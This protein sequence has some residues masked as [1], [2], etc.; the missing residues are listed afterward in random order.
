MTEG[1]PIGDSRSV[2]PPRKEG[3][4]A[5]PEKERVGELVTMYLR[6]QTWWASYQLDRRQQRESLKTSNR[7]E[8]RRKAPII[9]VELQR[10]RRAAP[11]PQVAIA[12]ATA[13]YLAHLKVEGLAPKTLVK[14]EKV[15]ETMLQVAY[16]RRLVNLSQLNL[17]FMDHDRRQR[18]DA[19]RSPKTIHNETTIIRQRVNLALSRQ[20]GRQRSAQRPEEPGAPSDKTAVLVTG[21][22][23]TDSVRCDGTGEVGLPAVGR[24]P[25]AIRGSAVADVGRCGLR[26]RCGSHSTQGWLETQDRRFSPGRNVAPGAGHA[27]GAKA[28]NTVG[29]LC[30]R[31]EQVPARDATNLGATV[32]SIAEA[33]AHAN[34]PTRGWEAAHVPPQ[35]HFEGLGKRDRQ[36]HRVELGGPRLRRHP[37]PLHTRARRSI[38]TGDA[39]LCGGDAGDRIYHNPRKARNH[40]VA[41]DNG[42][43]CYIDTLPRERRGRDSNPRCHF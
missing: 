41:N 6:G 21:R 43:R 39:A 18:K 25:H 35:V 26:A 3:P 24:Y 17:R 14:Y 11:V 16:E 19:G 15:L 27:G 13:E 40:D 12:T 7:K 37:G 1:A 4:I 36:R 38:A 31:L 2:S 33:F 29:V 5:K 9:E 34:R 22:S 30:R 28:E 20:D 10:G 8:A 23:R 42:A 32:A